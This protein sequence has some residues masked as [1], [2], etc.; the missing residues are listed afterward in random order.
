MEKWGLS[1]DELRQLKPD[2][3]LF[4]TSMLGRGGPYSRQPGFGPVLS[5]LSGMTGLTGWPDRAPTNPYGAY[6]DFVVPRFALPTIIAAL[7]YR[8]RTGHGQH[9]DMAQIEAALYFMAPPMLQYML[10]DYEPQRAGNR[11]P[12]AA[13]H[14]AYP[15]QGEDRWCI[16]ACMTDAHWQA[17]CQAMGCPAWTQ[18]ERFATL[19]GRKAHEDELEALLGQWTQGW[20]AE[21]LMHALQQAGVPA[22]TVH[23]NQ[24]VIEDAQLQHRG[25][26]VY[27]DHPGV[28]RHPVQRSEFR[29][30]QAAA[31]HRW[32]APLIG[33]HTAQVCKEILG[34]SEDEIVTLMAE[35][36]LEDSILPEGGAT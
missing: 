7:D 3:I 22:G 17:L 10:N 32:A 28:G 6:T 33:Q 25:H 23:T 27:L 19:L 35:G 16:I 31:E 12:A 11:H 30:S 15:C 2:V 13:P 36:V 34:M 9:L 4:S 20:E 5:S 8:R 1:Y 26:F 24:G 14:G 29:L 18:D 21:A